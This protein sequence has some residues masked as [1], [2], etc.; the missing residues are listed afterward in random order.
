MLCLSTWAMQQL[1]H[2][3]RN[4]FQPVLP[5]HLLP[6]TKLPPGKHSSL[7]GDDLKDRQKI[8]QADAETLTGR[9]TISKPGKCKR[10]HLGL[11][12]INHILV[13]QAGTKAQPAPST[14]V[15]RQKPQRGMV[16]YSF[17]NNMFCAGNLRNFNQT[18]MKLTA[19]PFVLD[20]ISEGVQL[21]F[22]S[23]LR[24][25]CQ[26]FKKLAMPKFL[27]LLVR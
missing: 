12:L 23:R 25:L 5:R 4:A 16:S 2:D 1:D 21:D 27:L 17:A 9:Q 8:V 11:L 10:R 15:R 14:Q 26:S 13:N 7:F 24:L 20:I 3:R 19:D 22:I 18:W 6:L